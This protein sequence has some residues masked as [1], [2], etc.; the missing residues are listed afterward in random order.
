LLAPATG[1]H[2]DGKHGEN[3]EAT[4]DPHNL[5]D[6]ATARGVCVTSP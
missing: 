6:G 1:S 2:K 4:E 5:L 3:Q